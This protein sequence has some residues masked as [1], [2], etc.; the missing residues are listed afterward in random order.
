MAI[1]QA[2]AGKRPSGEGAG[3][4]KIWRKFNIRA[5]CRGPAAPGSLAQTAAWCKIAVQPRIAGRSRPCP[6]AVLPSF[7][8][9]LAR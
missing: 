9:Q 7:H 4:W 6:F 8:A 3:N 2:R 5:Q 1:T